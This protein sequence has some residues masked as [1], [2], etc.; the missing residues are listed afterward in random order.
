MTTTTVNGVSHEVGE[1]QGTLISFLREHLGLTGTKPGCGE[2]ECGACTVLVDG[3]PAFSCQLDAR[4]V[5]GRSV[6]TVEG[7]A[8]DGRLH[9]VQRAL[10]EERASQCGYCTPGMAVRGAALLARCPEPGHE[11]IVAG[12]GPNVCRCGCYSRIAKALRRASSVP[13]EPRGPGNGGPPATNISGGA[14]SELARPRRPWDLCPPEEREWAELLGEGLVVVWPPPVREDGWPVGGGAWVHVAP[15]GEVTAFSGKVDVGQDNATSFRLLV[16]E[17]LG[18]ELDR[19]RVVLGD[20]DVCPF[21]VG[22]VGSRSMPDAGEALRRAAAGARQVLDELAL[23]GEKLSSGLRLEILRAEPPLRSPAEKRLVGSL[24]HAASRLDVVTGRRRYVSDLDLPGMVY[25]A[26]LRPPVQGARLI[27]VDPAAVTGLAHVTVV[28]DG[29]FVGV[30]AGSRAA[31]RQAADLLKAEWDLPAV[32]DGELAEYLRSHPAADEGWQRAVDEHEGDVEAGLAGAAVRLEATYTT[33]YIAHVP[34]ETRAAM[35]SWEDGRLTAWTGTQR[36]FAVRRSLADQLGVDEADVRVIVAPTG[37]GFGGKHD[38]AVALEAARLARAVGRPVKVHW[39]RGEEF[40]F[41]YMRP[42]AVIDVRAGLDAEGRVSAWDFL[43]VNAGPAG[44]AYPYR[45]ANRRTRYQPAASPVAQ[46]S[47]R[48]LGA[49]ANNFA[50]EC[51]M[52]ELAQLA[53]ADPVEFRLRHL[54]DERLATVLRAAV[55]R[56]GWVGRYDGNLDGRGCGV[57]VGLE[58]GGRVATCAEVRV[59]EDGSVRVTRVVSAYECGA[60]VNPDT[61]ENQVEGATVMALGGALFESIPWEGGRLGPFSLSNYRVPRFGDLPQVDVV[62]VDRPDLPS[63][64]AGETP[65][66]AVAPA[67]ANGIA[68]ATGLRLRSLPLVPGVVAAAS[69]ETA[70]PFAVR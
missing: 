5:A 61:V 68:A 18:T 10:A 70:S 60:I 50:R 19:V 3:E 51:H 22:T 8:V 31:A 1:W 46:G 53:G 57:A 28:R 38:G 2:G 17:E 13:S 40:Q 15:A 45:A 52:D 54:D 20:T 62:L 33:S 14:L 58:K 16:A 59:G 69:K 21:D 30:T 4:E 34:L 39:S 12:L 9:P 27:G 42:M 43:D 29:D 64:G 25:G 55:E 56:F 65:M 23:K 32:V 35:A 49:N 24:G 41:A 26:V 48:A 63:A 44:F 47:Y 67:I 36:P 66:I 7:L 11:D 37:S 6:T